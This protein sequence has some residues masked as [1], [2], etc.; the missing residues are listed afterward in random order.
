M[1]CILRCF[2]VYHGCKKW[3]V[4][5]VPAELLLAGCVFPFSRLLFFDVNSR[6][7][8]VGK[9]EE[10]RMIL[11]SPKWRGLRKFFAVGHKMADD[12]WNMELDW[13]LRKLNM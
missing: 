10:I 9:S 12:H 13:V 4:E 8:V 2:S 11:D 6:D 5:F 3:L 1:L 7:R